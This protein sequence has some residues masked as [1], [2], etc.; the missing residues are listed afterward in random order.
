MDSVHGLQ[1][2]IMGY[3]HGLISC[4][5]DSSHGLAKCHGLPHGLH[6]NP[7]IDQIVNHYTFQH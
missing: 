4:A 1:W 6:I 7:Y 5:M 2:N 3:P